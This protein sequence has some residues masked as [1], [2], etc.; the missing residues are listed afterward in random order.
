MADKDKK[1][2]ARNKNSIDGLRKEFKEYKKEI[3]K[4]E[5]EKKKDK[6][7]DSHKITALIVSI[8]SIV[9]TVS[10]GVTNYNLSKEVKAFNDKNDLL[11]ISVKE[12]KEK[13]EYDFN[14]EV[15]LNGETLSE[16]GPT[17]KFETSQGM[18]SNM[19]FIVYNGTGSPVVQNVIGGTIDSAIQITTNADKIYIVGRWGPNFTS[20]SKFSSY[21]KPE[22]LTMY[23]YAFIYTESHQ[24]INSLSLMYVPLTVKLNDKGKYILEVGDIKLMNEFD[25]NLLKLNPENDD[26]VEMID[27]YTKLNDLVAK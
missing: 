20:S 14:Y 15:T 6:V 19:K 24:G 13:S 12:H 17:F 27:N 21:E 25:V 16:K 7:W 22:E 26:M 10:F 1:D 8:C 2:I 11:L 3:E 5:G 9:V 23:D 4:K 18:I